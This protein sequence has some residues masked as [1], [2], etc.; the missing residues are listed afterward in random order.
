MTLW[1]LGYKQDPI[2]TTMTKETKL[3]AQLIYPHI[4]TWLHIK[5]GKFEKLRAHRKSNRIT[6]SIQACGTFKNN[7]Q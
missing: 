6:T 7:R 4:Q 1:T 5:Y 3:P 2:D